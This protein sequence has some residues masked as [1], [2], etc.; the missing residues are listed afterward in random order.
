MQRR[1]EV[2]GGGIYLTHGDVKRE[3][4]ALGYFAFD[5][6]NPTHHLAKVLADGQPQP[7][8]PIAARRRIIRLGEGAKQNFNLLTCHTNPCIAHAKMKN[9]GGWGGGEANFAHGRQRNSAIVGEFGGVAEQI[10]QNLAQFNGVGRQ[11]AQPQTEIHLKAVAVLFDQRP[12]CN[13]H[14]I[15]QGLHRKDLGVQIHLA[16]FNFRKVEN[17]VDEREQ[18]IGRNVDFIEPNGEFFIFAQA[19][20]L[21]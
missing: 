17:I 15:H 10:E 14:I 2:G 18:M 12:C 16:R 8:A 7:R 6:D 9:F 11:Q 19:G 1:G 13:Q 4:G 3:S 21:L 5:R 20:L